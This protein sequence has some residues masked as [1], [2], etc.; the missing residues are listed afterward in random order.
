MV[1][2]LLREQSAKFLKKIACMDFI[3][4][5]FG[6]QLISQAVCL[7]CQQQ[8]KQRMHTSMKLKQVKNLNYELITSPD[9]HRRQAKEKNWKTAASLRVQRSLLGVAIQF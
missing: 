8:L 2:R 9:H 6:E 4:D 7:L 3:P 5:F 1:Y